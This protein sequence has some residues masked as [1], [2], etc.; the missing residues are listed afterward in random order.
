MVTSEQTGVGMP[1]DEFIR[2]NDE[3]PFELINGER[4]A[5]M[6]T[7]AGQS[8]VIDTLYKSLRVHTDANKLDIVRV[9]ATFV[10]PDN[11]DVNWVAGSRI[12]DLMFISAERFTVY[13]E[14]HPDWHEKPYLIVPDFVIEVI[15]LN[16]R[17]S[18]IDEKIDAYLQDGVRL[19]WIID[20]Q[21]RKVIVHALD[22]E[23]P[24]YVVGD[25]T[26]SAGDV[27]PGYEITL[28]TLFG[29]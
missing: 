12:P 4:K 5:K 16:D 10:L 29:S 21:R 11:Y 22:M 25:A 3:Q 23:Q 7:I 24:R 1:L 28:P 8:E 17:F 26:L 19:I 13:Q 27:I 6:P 2:L 15:S 18:D 14:T 20:P 9:E